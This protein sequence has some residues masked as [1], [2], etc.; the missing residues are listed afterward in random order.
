LTITPAQLRAAR[1]LLGISQD[2][3]ADASEVAKRTI[4]AFESEARAPYARTIAALREALEARG[5]IFIA[6]NGEGPGV[7]LRKR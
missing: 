2:D 4:A 5:C 1:A 6:E 3:L 7:R